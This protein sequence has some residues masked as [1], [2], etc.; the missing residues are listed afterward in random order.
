VQVAL[1]V[2]QT[3]HVLGD[4]ADEITMISVAVLI[5]A[6]GVGWLLARR[7]TRRLVRLA[8]IAEEVSV[9]GDV[10][11]EVP[12]DGRD[13]VSRLSASFNT[14]LTRI[15]AARDAQDRLVQDA[16]HELRTPLTSLRTNAS[17]LRRL[18]ELPP[19]ARDRLLDDMQGETRELSD[20]VDELVELAL[21]RGGDEPEEPMDL[22]EVTRNAAARVQR[23]TGRDVRVDAECVVWGRRQGLERAVSN[24]LENAAKFDS[25]FDPI[26]VRAHQGAVTVADRGPGI[27]AQ[28]TA[29]VFDRF[30][31]AASAR[32][33]PGSG[34]GLAIVRDVAEGHGGSVFAGPRPGGGAAVG[35]TVSAARLLPISKPDHVEASPGSIRV[36]DT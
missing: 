11:H 30:Y 13:E 22:A 26:E 31:R 7:I 32:G 27:D 2:D 19:H 12:V 17:I 18:D 9:H 28:D 10:E 1:D 25:G 20:L 23:R 34:L 8:G 15:A 33:L 14:M 4:M 21:S 5:V 35:F 24:L 3:R 36:D 6:A 16:A 29:R